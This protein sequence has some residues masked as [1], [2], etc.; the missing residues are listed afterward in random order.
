MSIH[1][2]LRHHKVRFPFSDSL[3]LERAGWG[4]GRGDLL[5][6][7][8]ET[9]QQSHLLNLV[10]R[11]PVLSLEHTQAPNGSDITIMKLSLS[12]ATYWL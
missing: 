1:R 7:T 4:L 2:H 8:D 10:P 5:E 12:L 11:C 6:A 9:A 3:P